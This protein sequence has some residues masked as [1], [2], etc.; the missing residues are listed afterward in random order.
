MST[1]F[2]WQLHGGKD[3]QQAQ[4]TPPPAAAWQGFR[5]TPQTVLRHQQH[6]RLPVMYPQVKKG[7][8]T[9]APGRKPLFKN[10]VWT[11]EGSNITSQIQQPS[12]PPPPGLHTPAAYP[13]GVQNHQPTQPPSLGL[14][15]SAPYPPVAMNDHYQA[16]NAPYG[17]YHHAPPPP[18][19]PPTP[20]PSEPFP[21]MHPMHSMFSPWAYQTTY[22]NHLP[23]PP[24]ITPTV[25]PYFAYTNMNGMEAY[26]RQMIA[27]SVGPLS[28]TLLHD[29]TSMSMTTVTS[30]ATEPKPLAA[31]TVMTPNSTVSKGSEASK[32]GEDAKSAGNEDVKHAT[33][34]S[35]TMDVPKPTITTKPKLVIGRPPAI[36]IKLRV[37]TDNQKEALMRT[38]Q[39]VKP[40]LSL[41]RPPL[42]RRKNV[43]EADDDEVES[44]DTQAVS[45]KLVKDVSSEPAQAVRIEQNAEKTPMVVP[46]VTTASIKQ[47]IFHVP[48]DDGKPMQSD[49]DK[50]HKRSRRWDVMPANYVPQVGIQP[51]R[52]EVKLVEFKGPEGLSSKRDQM[53]EP[54]T[55]ANDNTEKNIGIKV[56]HTPQTLDKSA[57]R[58]SNMEPKES[59]T[60]DDKKMVKR[61]FSDLCE[62]LSE[63]SDTGNLS[64]SGH[65]RNSSSPKT[66]IPTGPAEASR[67]STAEPAAPEDIERDSDNGSDFSSADS[68]SDL[69]SDDW[70]DDASSLQSDDDVLGPW[71]ELG[72]IQTRD[73]SL[74]PWTPADSASSPGA[75]DMT[76]Q[77]SVEETEVIAKEGEDTT[78]SG[79]ELCED[80]TEVC[81]SLDRGPWDVM[82]LCENCYDRLGPGFSILPKEIEE[83]ICPEEPTKTIP[84]EQFGEDKITEQPSDSL[85]MEVQMERSAV[86]RKPIHHVREITK[87]RPKHVEPAERSTKPALESLDASLQAEQASAIRRKAV[88]RK[89]Y[90]SDK[91]TLAPHQQHFASNQPHSS[92]STTPAGMNHF[93]Q[94]EYVTTGA[95]PTRSTIRKLTD[96]YNFKPNNILEAEQCS[97]IKEKHAHRRSL[98]QT[99]D[100]PELR[101]EVT[102]DTPKQL[103]QEFVAPPPFQLSESTSAKDRKSVQR[104]PIAPTKYTPAPHQSLG[105]SALKELTF[106]GQSSEYVTTGA[107]LTRSTVRKLADTYGFEPNPHGYRY[108]T[109]VAVLALDGQWDEGKLTEMRQGSVRVHFKG[110]NK[111]KYDQWIKLGSRR[112]RIL[113]DEVPSD[114]KGTS[115]SGYL[116]EV[117]ENPEFENEAKSRRK[118]QQYVLQDE[119]EPV[120]PAPEQPEQFVRGRRKHQIPTDSELG[121]EQAGGSIR[122]RRRHATSSRIKSVSNTVQTTDN[123]TTTQSTA[124]E[125]PIYRT[126]GAFMT[127]RARRQLSGPSGFGFNLHGYE[128][129]QHV[130]VLQSDKRWYEARLIALENVSLRVHY[131]GMDFEEWIPET[132]R[133]IKIMSE[134]D[135]ENGTCLDDMEPLQTKDEDWVPLVRVPKRRRHEHSEVYTVSKRSKSQRAEKRQK[136]E[137]DADGAIAEAD[138]NLATL[139]WMEREQNLRRSLRHLGCD[140][141]GQRETARDPTEL[142]ALLRPGARIEARDKNKDWL[143]AMVVAVRGYRVLVHYEG[144]PSFYDE[145]MDIN[146]K[147]LHIGEREGSEECEG[148]EAT[149]IQEAYIKGKKGQRQNQLQEPEEHMEPEAEYFR[150]DMEGVEWEES[151]DWQVYCNQCHIMIKQFR[152]YCTYC[153]QPSEGS[154]YQ[155]FEL[156]LWCF[157]HQFPDYHQHPRSSFA[158]QSIM[159]ADES[160][161]VPVK[162]ELVST[163]EKDVVDVDYQ[164]DTEDQEL[165]RTDMPLE[166]DKGY[167]YLKRWAKRKICSFCNDDDTSGQYGGFIGPFRIATV[168]RRG[169]EKK[170]TFWVHDACARYSPEVFVTKENEWYNV[171]AALRRGRGMRCAFCKEKGAT[172]GCFDSKCSRSFHLPCTQKPVSYFESGVI[173]WCPTHEA[174]FNKKEIYENV[175]RCDVCSKSLQE[176]TWH[177]CLP[178][179][180]TGY[181]ST[182]DLCP[183][184]FENKFPE[185]HEHDR[186]FFEETSV[187]FIKETEAEKQAEAARAKLEANAAVIRKPRLF[188]KGR[189]KNKLY[190]SYCWTETSVQWRKGYDGVLMCEGCFDRTSLDNVQ[191]DDPKRGPLVLDANLADKYAASIEDYTHQPYLTRTSCSATK[192]D[193]TRSDALYLSSYEP[194]DHQL[195]SLAFDSSYFDIPGRAPRWATHSGTDYHAKLS[196]FHFTG[197]WLPQTVRRAI[198][199]FTRK[200]E[201]ILSNFLGR[202]TDAIESFLLQRKCCGVDINPL[203]P[204]I[205]AAVALSQRNCSFAVPPGF[206]SA[207]YRPVLVQSDS[208]NL[209]GALFEDESYDHVLSHPPYKDCVV[210]ST[211]IEGDLSR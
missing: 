114:T 97:A 167:A 71:V 158:V 197:T 88:Y 150:E 79:G 16:P 207:E 199:R 166:S 20:P 90:G 211:H 112:L 184:C 74:T 87:V 193:D 34:L 46:I 183:E 164:S 127:R 161:P 133:R 41:A 29:M 89:F 64:E 205:Q 107:F 14:H 204:V 157:S 209:S 31:A 47:P 125:A 208:R 105:S 210:Y 172:V 170:R 173:F 194:G 139:E 86:G 180:E 15:A 190:C 159:N 81:F 56:R 178:C 36:E 57:K 7:P 153:E 67:P 145:W 49:T 55:Y 154:D 142:R 59:N 24:P 11:R 61:D 27:E 113:P 201:K 99:R 73:S 162:G 9:F 176:S 50:V 23:S 95:F 104:K 169:E 85:D 185:N 68:L 21:S 92:E 25:T 195:F 19:L 129:N 4:P 70:D 110:Y 54:T 122:R 131:C 77:T 202:G 135:L 117:E 146:S 78:I 58:M 106:D 10:A 60:T 138:S 63:L 45:V 17:S 124:I 151:A 53:A 121:N 30:K 96:V 171:T 191:G 144:Y 177:T 51:A 200:H 187:A 38:G 82:S 147:R 155:S 26:G 134:L 156:C 43:L 76:P 186:D 8:A 66:S 116:F 75:E 118:Q 102:A 182:F 179:S 152:Y 35:K 149:T 40:T 28:P 168:N 136:S 52:N 48:H 196:R 22:E 93:V 100:T 65:E 13:H 123:D 132:S 119:L 192:F 148:L 130:K 6:Q 98:V 80:C 108:G 12:Q 188:P 83:E 189:Q 42:F 37:R 33:P 94:S 91:Y 103:Q 115:R 206:T 5:D 120:E 126:T 72:L 32:D 111:D 141:S 163:Y 84:D 3:T 109:R 160:G 165:L 1:P 143:A 175:F 18:P 39:Y 203:V 140:R 198:L 181:F 44:K 128:Y 2:G 137:E 174:Y 101:P 62:N 69:D